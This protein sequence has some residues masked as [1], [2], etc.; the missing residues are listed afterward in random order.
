VL[1]DVVDHSY[2]HIEFTIER[3]SA[4]LDQCVKLSMLDIDPLQQRLVKAAEHN[5]ALLE[6]FHNTWF[7]DVDDTVSRAIELSKK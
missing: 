5:R 6:T 1:D 2:D 3:Q 4:I 7:Q